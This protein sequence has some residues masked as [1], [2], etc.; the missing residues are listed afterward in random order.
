METG[1]DLKG[2]FGNFIK[3]QKV[4]SQQLNSKTIDLVLDYINVLKLFKVAFLYGWH[5]WKWIE[6]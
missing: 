3:S 2:L 5:E 6:T 1:G 4:S